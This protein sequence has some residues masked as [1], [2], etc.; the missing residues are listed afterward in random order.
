MDCGTGAALGQQLAK[1][2]F[3]MHGGVGVGPTGNPEQDVL[4]NEMMRVQ[5]PTGHAPDW[6]HQ[7][8]A[9]Q[10]QQH[11][12]Q[13]AMRRQQNEV[14]MLQQQQMEEA[15]RTSSARHPQQQQQPHPHHH[16]HAPGMMGPGMMG[17]MMY[18]AG[19]GGFMGAAPS[20]MAHAP[21]AFA[22]NTVAMPTATNAAKTEDATA[23]SITT[24]QEQGDSGWVEKLRDAEW[25]QD[26]TEAQVFTL[27]GQPEQTMEEHGRSSEFYKF[28]DQ[29][30]NKELLID[31]ETGEV[32][33]GPGPDPDMPEDTAYLKEWATAEALG[34]PP[35]VF[36]PMRQR[37]HGLD[38]QR[39]GYL[40]D[41]G[42]EALMD[43]FG[44]EHNADL[45]E[46][47]REYAEMQERMQRA[48]NDTDYPF[49][50]NN[51]YM[52]HD[53]PMEEGL[54]MLQLAN[55]AEAALAFEAVCQK[56]PENIESW[57]LLGKTQAEN[58]KDN[59]AIIALNHARMLNPKDIAVHAALAV[60]HTN[61]HNVQ[62]ALQALRS[63]LLSQPQYESLGSVPLHEGEEA[64]ADLDEMDDNY[65]Y[66]SP[67]EYR[68][69]RA[70]LNAAVEMNPN[71]P[72]LHASLGVLHNL[73]RRFE[74]AAMNFRRAVDLN[75]D[76]PQMWNR[77]GAT[78]ANGNKP[79]EALEAYNRA[80]DI[81]PGYV[82][83]MY[84]M[85]VS[86]SNL[87]QYPLAAKE[88]TRAIALQAGGTNPQ[89][90]VSRMATRGLWDLLRMTLNL[91]DRTDLVEL[92]WQQDVKPF[93]KEFGLEDMAF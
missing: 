27:E 12:Q 60:S 1:D 26:Y 48:Q 72:Q 81:N 51:P 22:G 6:T 85:A 30:R 13:V 54:A 58:E 33:Q 42:D 3:H 44:A 92:S 88:I 65:F 14:F 83:A 73:S 24:E 62:A 75:P 36:E 46:W 66:A 8:V 20:M 37:P 86:Y 28:M 78:L 9:H 49:E 10:Q 52:Y 21:T 32:V 11:P 74:E 41:G 77:L 80:L 76:D 56:E 25:A 5:S 4:M 79:Q 90:E 50:P 68:D 47:A 69:C 45:D 23:T 2:A 39:E 61:E 15:F 64:E 84:N 89:S 71:D 55:L 18:G 29:I 17:P 87:A 38:R 82:R 16:L 53:K 40:Q 43:D 59:L 91:M 63:W 35:G 34:L 31:E 70:L 57:R 7:F 67:S 93:L 19:M